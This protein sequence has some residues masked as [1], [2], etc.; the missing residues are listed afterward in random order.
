MSY[1]ESIGG[2]GQGLI[3]PSEGNNLEGGTVEN[4]F[5]VP[6]S[7]NSGVYDRKPRNVYFTMK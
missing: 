6:S 5:S 3:P 1:S 4:F 7:K 2:L